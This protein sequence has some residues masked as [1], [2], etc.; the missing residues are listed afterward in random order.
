MIVITGPI[1]SGKS[2]VAVALATALNDDGVTAE[3]IDLDLVHD[4]FASAGAT[5]DGSVWQ[6]ARRDAAAIANLTG[7][8]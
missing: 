3:V 6:L 5:S 1:A 2:S 7:L 8:R 4:R